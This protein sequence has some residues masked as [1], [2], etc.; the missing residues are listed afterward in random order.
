MKLYTNRPSPYGRK[1]LVAAHEKNLIDAIT[2]VQVD[3]WVD[4]PE[5]LATTPLGK[6]PALVTDE[7]ALIT[8]SSVIAEYFDKV[9]SGPKLIGDDRLA[10]LGRTALAKGLIDAAFALVIERRRPAHL[11]W[12][13][14]LARQRRAVERTLSIIATPEQFDLGGLT[15]ACALGYL[16]FRLPEIAWRALRP[17]LAGW[18][19]EAAQRPSMRATKP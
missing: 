1:A 9:G 8:D 5:L 3:P 10:A 2:I 4:P 16:D 19:D 13:A 18:F 17:E 14:W 12:D 15:L 11:Q 7:G 6:V